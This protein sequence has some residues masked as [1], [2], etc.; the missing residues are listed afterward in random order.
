MTK[1]ALLAL[2]RKALDETST[3]AERATSAQMLAR[4]VV[5]TLSDPK[6]MLLV[7]PEHVMSEKD[8][9]AAN[10]ANAVV[11]SAI[12]QDEVKSAPETGSPVTWVD[13]DPPPPARPSPSFGGEWG[14]P[15]RRRR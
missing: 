3:D 1:T 6:T 8:R 5:K 14:K 4:E 15:P 12:M 11:R 7:E 10:A 2:A 13:L 9:Q